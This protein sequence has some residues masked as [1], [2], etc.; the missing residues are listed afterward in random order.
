MFRQEM[1]EGFQHENP[2]YWL[3]FGRVV[4]RHSRVSD[5]F[6]CAVLAVIN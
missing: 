4:G 1:H 2:D 6:T 3:N 5:L